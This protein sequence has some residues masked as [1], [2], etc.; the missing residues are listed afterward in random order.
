MN[1]YNINNTIKALIDELFASVDEET[2]EINM[3]I[4]A[5]LDAMY[6]TRNEKLENIAFYIKNLEAEASA[7]KAESEKLKARQKSAENH[8]ARLKRY[9]IDNLTE[10]DEKKFTSEDSIISFTI[11]E[12]PA[13]S[14]TDIDKLP[15]KYLVKTVEVKPDKRAI[16]EMLKADKKVAGAELVINKSINFK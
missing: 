5:E 9:L 3:D 6:V 2:G 7:L 14:I 13:V 12:T 10:A 16:G 1:L 15:K 4:K 8:A 11:R